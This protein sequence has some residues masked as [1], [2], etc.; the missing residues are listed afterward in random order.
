[1]SHAFW[2]A[3][4]SDTDTD[5]VQ[6]VMHFGKRFGLTLALTLFN[7]S[8]ILES[9]LVWHWHCSMSHAFWKA[10]WSDTGTDTV[11]WVMHFGKRFGLTL[12]LF[13]EACILESVLVWHWHWHCSMSH[14]FWKAFWFD[15]DTDTVQW[16]MHFGK[17]FGL[18]LTLTLFNESCILESVLVWHWHCSMSHAFWKAFWSDTDTVQWVMHFGKRFG[19]TLTLFNESCILESVLVWHWHCSMSHAFWKAFWSD[20]DTDTVQWVMHFGKRFGLTLTLALFNESCIL[21]SVLVWHWHWHCSMS[22]A[23]WKAFWSDTDTVQWVMHF[24]KRFGLTLALTLFNES[25]ILESVLV[26]HWHCSMSHA[27]W[28]AF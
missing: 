2:K 6:W 28:K 26:W 23:F 24:G 4:W 3:F 25:C 22:H 15:T 16:G 14:A 17:R 9:V 12:T 1:M 7:E 8:C 11:Q 18:T 21:E 5:T 10:F 27:F 13:N 20:T 19:L